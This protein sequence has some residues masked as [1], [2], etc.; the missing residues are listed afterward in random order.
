VKFSQWK[1]EEGRNRRCTQINADKKEDNNRVKKRKA[2]PFFF[3]H[4]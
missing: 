3:L 1:K 2:L 4:N